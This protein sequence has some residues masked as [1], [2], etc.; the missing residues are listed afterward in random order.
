[1]KKYKI[2]L[3]LLRRK[4]GLIKGKTL[5]ED[6]QPS[7]LRE[8]SRL[9]NEHP[10]EEQTVVEKGR[11]SGPLRVLGGL[12]P[13]RAFGNA[14]YKYSL[15][16]QSKL[17]AILK[18]GSPPS[19]SWLQPPNLKTPPYIT[20]N[21]DVFWKK[22]DKN[23]RFLILASDG[24]FDT[25][26]NNDAVSSVVDYMNNSATDMNAATHLLRI[27]LEEDKG[28]KHLSRLLSLPPKISRSY[29]DDISIQIIFFKSS[30]LPNLQTETEI[31]QRL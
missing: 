19:Y 14:R 8:L 18:F 9:H 30:V 11:D 16:N 15:S 28:Q 26:S 5:T 22:L 7:N 2:S 12:M 24:L 10:G 25:I 3:K 27:A 20:A 31:V 17:D 4:E 21:P 6:H 13:S 23:D 29:R 1:M